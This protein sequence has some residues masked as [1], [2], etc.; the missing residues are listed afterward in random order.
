MSSL[1]RLFIGVVFTISTV[2]IYMAVLVSTRDLRHDK[3]ITAAAK[4]IQIPGISLSTSYI[5]NRIPVYG[6]SSNDFYLGMKKDS[7]MS[8]VYDK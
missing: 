6:D 5:E 4:L 8:F 2:F 7:F 1:T 3:N